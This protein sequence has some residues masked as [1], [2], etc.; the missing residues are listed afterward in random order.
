MLFRSR[1]RRLNNSLNRQKSALIPLALSVS[2]NRG[3]HVPR[4]V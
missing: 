3:N 2:I 4:I 1:R